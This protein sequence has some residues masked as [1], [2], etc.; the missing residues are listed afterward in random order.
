MGVIGGLVKARKFAIASGCSLIDQN[1][2]AQRSS[3]PWVSETTNGCCP[4][5]LRVDMS[6]SMAALYCED[7]HLCA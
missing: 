4:V 7:I 1:R 5:D 2:A 3:L 6:L